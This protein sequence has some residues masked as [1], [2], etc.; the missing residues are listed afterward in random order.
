MPTQAAL[1]D[2]PVI[3]GFCEIRLQTDCLVVAIDS[4]LKIGFFCAKVTNGEPRSC[5][6]FDVNSICNLGN[7]APFS[8]G[9]FDISLL[10]Q[11]NCPDDR[12][13][14]LR[15]RR[16]FY[17]ALCGLFCFGWFLYYSH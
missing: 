8:G 16:I 3:Q 10:L 4:L 14:D 5:S 2:T 1:R 15:R 11:K 7:S 9:T 17:G 6:E 13:V 12:S